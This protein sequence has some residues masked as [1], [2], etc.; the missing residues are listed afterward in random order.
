MND[1][2][3]TRVLLTRSAED[4]ADW[5]RELRA[6]GYEAVELAAKTVRGEVSPVMAL[7]ILPMTISPT[8]SLVATVSS[9]V[10]PAG[11]ILPRPP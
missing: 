2:R 1:A 9:N 10:I 6:R 4:N 8:T 3:R 11:I 5:A 7:T